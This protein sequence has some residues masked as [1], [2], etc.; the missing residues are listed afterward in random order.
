MDVSVSKDTDIVVRSYLAQR[1]LKIGR[2][3]EVHR[4]GVRWRVFDQTLAEARGKF[5]D[6]PPDELAT[7]ADEAAVAA[8]KAAGR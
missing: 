5:A 6:M 2:P 3:L 7:L 1:G 8:R 4:G